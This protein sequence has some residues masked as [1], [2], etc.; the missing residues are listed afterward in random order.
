MPGFIGGDGCERDC[1]CPICIA[2]VQDD[3]DDESDDNPAHLQY[4]S[5]WRSEII[6]TEKKRE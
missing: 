3:S 5:F 6:F 2:P 4:K 1:E